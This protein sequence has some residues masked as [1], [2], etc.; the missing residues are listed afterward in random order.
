VSA[1]LAARRTSAAVLADFKRATDAYLDDPARSTPR[2]DYG[3][4][5]WRLSSELGSV[6]QQLEAEALCG[7][8][9]AE[10]AHN[11]VR[12]AGARGFC[13]ECAPGACGRFAPA[14][15]R[16]DQTA[17]Q[18]AEVRLVLEAFDWATDDRE[19]A[20]EQIDEIVRGDER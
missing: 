2:P 3:M 10:R 17:A 14:G 16:D 9:H 6:L 13:H 5:A 12:A 15:A 4:W 7:C 18:L 11:A 20:L 19:F 1:E 8:G